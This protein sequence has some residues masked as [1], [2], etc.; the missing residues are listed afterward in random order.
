V[1]DGGLGVP[2][3]LTPVECEREPSRA[4]KAGEPRHGESV[5]T[6][7][8]P[9]V[10]RPRRW[11]VLLHNDD[12]TSMDFVVRVLMEDFDKDLTEATHIMLQVH[13]N[14]IGVA[15]V[16]PRDMAETKVWLVIKKARDES[17]PL[18]ATTEP[19]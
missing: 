3:I 6:R 12:Y 5:V 2:R 4:E 14:G 11:K 19:E 17:M 10:K 16:Y 15:G 18:L 1:P 13:M 7:E 9:A 8:R